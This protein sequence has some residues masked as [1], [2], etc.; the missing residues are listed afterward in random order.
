[1]ALEGFLK[2]P[3]VGASDVSKHALLLEASSIRPLWASPQRPPY[4]CLGLSLKNVSIPLRGQ[5]SAVVAAVCFWMPQAAVSYLFSQQHTNVCL[6]K[7][8]VWPRALLGKER[9][10]MVLCLTE[11][12]Q[13][14]SMQQA[15]YFP[16]MQEQQSHPQTNLKIPTKV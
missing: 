3:S 4:T 11:L 5:A 6:S 7:S 2:V 8:L 1:M 15:V 12:D 14:C 13:Y 16:Y 9:S 10:G